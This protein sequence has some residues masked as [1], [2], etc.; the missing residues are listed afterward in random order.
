VADFMASYPSANAEIEGHTDNAGA[1][2]YN[3]KLSQDRADAVR[4]YLISTY[5][6]AAS[7]LTAKGYGPSKPIADNKT[8]EGRA[9]NRRVV[10]TLTAVK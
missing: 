8:K 5:H 4:Q 7:R 2:D 9:K 10:A 3:V 1:A 6:I